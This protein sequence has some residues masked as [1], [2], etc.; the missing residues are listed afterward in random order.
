MNPESTVTLA[1][2]GLEPGQAAEFADCYAKLGFLTTTH[3]TTQTP[4]PCAHITNGYDYPP[5]CKHPEMEEE[6][7][8]LTQ[9]AWESE[10]D[11]Q[12]DRLREIE[13]RIAENPAL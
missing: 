7:R 1:I 6:R 13:R 10:V 12:M 4:N 5:E 3:G 9:A 11:R 8:L 2:H